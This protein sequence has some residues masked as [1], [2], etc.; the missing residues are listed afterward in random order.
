VNST[1]LRHLLNQLGSAGQTGALYVDGTPGG[2]L[3]LVAGHLTHAESPACPGVGERLVASGRLSARTWAAAYDEGRGQHRVGRV[4]IRDGHL[5]QHELACRVIAT[6]CDTTHALLQGTDTAIRFVP[7]ERHWL[8]VI[9][10]VELG[11]LI[12]ETARR[13]RTVPAPRTD[14][15][16]PRAGRT[17]PEWARRNAGPDH[18]ALR[19]ARRGVKQAI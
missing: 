19:R 8:G 12:H 4:L 5:G 18:A 13:L 3:Y 14:L 2:V 6:I 10:Q 11:A 15:D 16:P 1:S 7:G 9:T 17:H